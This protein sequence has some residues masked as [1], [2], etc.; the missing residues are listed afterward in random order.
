MFTALALMLSFTPT[1]MPPV[2]EP[3]S[4]HLIAYERANLQERNR[5]KVRI[6]REEVVV[7]EGLFTEY[8]NLAISSAMLNRAFDPA[9]HVAEGFH[10]DP[11]NLSK[12]DMSVSEPF[13]RQR[14]I[15]EVIGVGVSDF[16]GSSERRLQNILVSLE[17]YDGLIIPQGETFSFNDRLGDVTEEAGYA[18]ERT[19]LN[20][21]SAWGLGGGICQISTNIFRAALN[22]GLPILERRA[23]SYVIDKYAPTGLDATIYKEQQDLQFTNDTPGDILMRVVRRDDHLAVFFFG[24]RDRRV[25][26]QKTSHWKGYDERIATNWART[27]KKDALVLNEDFSA[28]YRGTY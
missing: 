15:V 6:P 8:K 10:F 21:N 19:I 23:H 1:A 22:A 5:D 28:N 20:G 11:T 3:P 13:L 17:R 26:L 24:T 9:N 27:I 12:L 18:W 14:G 7:P 16:T 2:I 4:P 25:E